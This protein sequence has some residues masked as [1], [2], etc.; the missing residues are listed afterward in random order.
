MIDMGGQMVSVLEGNK[1]AER[2]G[3]LANGLKPAD[4]QSG[5]FY[6]LIIDLMKATLSAY[7]Q[8]VAY[9]NAN[10]Y[11]LLAGACR[12]LLELAVFTK[13]VLLSEAS[14]RRFCE[15]RLIDGYE[16]FEALKNLELHYDAN[17]NTTA[18]DDAMLTMKATMAEEKVTARS[19]LNLRDLLV[20]VE[21][22]EEYDTLN[23]VCSKLVHVCA[24]SVMAVN[25]EVNSFPYV[26]E[27]LFGTGTMFVGVAHIAIKEYN[28]AHGLKPINLLEGD[29]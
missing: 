6:H 22:K 8:L 1:V 13:Y 25:E 28:A 5:W 26:K 15:D 12:N 19:H 2:F 14:A 16:I 27:I 7:E 29:Q 18:L 3:R 21:M 10:N 17:A 20:Q 4:V 23:R 9:Y 24:W 11:K